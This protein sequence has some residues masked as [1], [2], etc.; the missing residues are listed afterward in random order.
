MGI[1]VP[2]ADSL[3]P[4][5]ARVTN[6]SLPLFS[7]SLSISL[8]RPPYKLQF[9]PARF[10]TYLCTRSEHSHTCAF[11][12]GSLLGAGSP[13]VP[14]SHPQV[15]PHVHLC[16]LI[17]VG[18]QGGYLCPG[19]LSSSSLEA[20]SARHGVR[21]E[22]APK[23]GDALARAP[24]VCSLGGVEGSPALRAL[25]LLQ[26]QLKGCNWNHPQEAACQLGFCHSAQGKGLTHGGLCCQEGWV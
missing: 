11:C 17:A 18:L 3:A 15:L 8:L 24:H 20:P 23:T 5:L 4:E 1:E 14:C 9:S 13:P 26:G 21:H 2:H 7:L 6:S 16:G 10:L 19:V 25:L 22:Q 12:P